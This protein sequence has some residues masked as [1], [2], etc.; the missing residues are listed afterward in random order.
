VSA[1]GPCDTSDFA[2]EEELAC[3]KQEAWE[4]GP[5]P[6]RG[7]HKPMC[8]RAGIQSQIESI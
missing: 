6:E 5:G 7:K 3:V 1:A 4:A 8:L 2:V